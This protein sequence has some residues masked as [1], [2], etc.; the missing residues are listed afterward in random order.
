MGEGLGLTCTSQY[1]TWIYES[2]DNLY[3][4]K[5]ARTDLV[6]VVVF[7]YHP[8]EIRAYYIVWHSLPE[9]TS[10]SFVRGDAGSEC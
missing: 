1:E 2:E 5:I 9:C 3:S 8:E 6:F 4:G 10:Q 7:A